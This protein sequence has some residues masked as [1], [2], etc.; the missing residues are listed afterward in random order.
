MVNE[1]RSCSF[2]V[3]TQDGRRIAKDN[4][5]VES[6]QTNHRNQLRHRIVRPERRPLSLLPGGYLCK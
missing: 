3:M 5:V 4:E 1:D 2:Y 6:I